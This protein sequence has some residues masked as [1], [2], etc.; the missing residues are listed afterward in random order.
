MTKKTL[1]LAMFIGMPA[2]A[3]APSGGASTGVGATKAVWSTMVGYF[4]AAAEQVP[5]A[6]YSFKPVETVRT[7]GQMVG[8][9]AGAQN[10]MCA[11][12]LGEAQ[13]SEDDI[14]KTVTTK[15]GLVTALKASSDYCSRAY[16]ISDADAAGNTKLFGQDMSKMFALSLNAA[17]AGEHYG[18]LVTYMRIKG[19]VPPSSQPAP[20]R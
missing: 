20:A 10:M 19:M 8:H 13:K 9:L 14:E 15:A 7:F 5:E 12:A 2:F 18:N 11:A 17:H 6:E 1:L 4:T 3:Q 16:G